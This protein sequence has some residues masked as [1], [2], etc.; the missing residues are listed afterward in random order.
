MTPRH[1]DLMDLFFAI[2][3]WLVWRRRTNAPLRLSIVRLPFERWNALRDQFVSEHGPP[4]A[5]ATVGELHFIVAGVPVGIKP[6][7]D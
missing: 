3:S 4:R 7:G 1:F 6:K 2:N 5:F